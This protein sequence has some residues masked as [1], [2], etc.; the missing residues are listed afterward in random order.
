MK[1]FK[2]TITIILTLLF[3]TTFSNPALSYGSGTVHSSSYT[4]IVYYNL[5]PFGV[6]VENQSY[7]KWE[8]W[9]VLGNNV[10]EHFNLGRIPNIGAYPFTIGGTSVN[11]L[12]SDGSLRATITNSEFDL[13]SY[14]APPDV[15]YFGGTAQREILMN[16]QVRA[17]CSP[18]YG[19]ICYDSSGTIYTGSRTYS[20]TMWF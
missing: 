20:F 6:Y 9:G 12:Y 4:F 11:R 15:R 5:V 3:I 2:I 18:T 19:I 16:N 13:G 1:K 10:Y 8:N 7:E 14:I 17:H